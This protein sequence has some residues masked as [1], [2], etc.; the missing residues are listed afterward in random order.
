MVKIDELKRV[1][2]EIWRAT[3]IEIRNKK[4]RF[5]DLRD[6]IANDKKTIER[7]EKKVKDLKQKKKKEEKEKNK[8][9]AELYSYQF[10]YLPSVSPTQQKSKN[11][12]WSINLKIGGLK[13]KIYLGSDSNV[14]LQ[15]DTI[16]KNSTFVLLGER[17]YSKD[18]HEI[19]KEEI[20]KVIQQNLANDLQNDFAG[21][22]EKWEK[23]ELRMW[24]YLNL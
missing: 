14:R 11:Y 9:K 19:L 7:L 21:I 18:G 5:S 8:L 20:R 2:E 4:Y 13:R 16:N 17:Q 3:P 22:N 6:S 23:N 12:Q 10:E 15:M 1:E 24:D